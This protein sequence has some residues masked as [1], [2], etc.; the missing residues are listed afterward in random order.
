[1][2]TIGEPVMTADA[3]GLFEMS[4]LSP[5]RTGLPFVVWISPKSVAPHDGSVK[6]SKGPRVRASELISVAIRPDVRVVAGGELSH[7]ELLL[8]ERWVELNREVLL[9]F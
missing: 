7:S 6:V 5:K 1:M 4:N 9:R 8:L 2:K 3:E